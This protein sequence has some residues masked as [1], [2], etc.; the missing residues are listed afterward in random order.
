MDGVRTLCRSGNR[1]ALEGRLQTG[2]M[3]QR[4]AW[5]IFDHTRSRC[6]TPA[7]ERSL[8]HPEERVEQPLG[9]LEEPLLGGGR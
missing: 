1:V 9:A 7:R 8:V 6:A 3:E 2:L 5:S 4:L